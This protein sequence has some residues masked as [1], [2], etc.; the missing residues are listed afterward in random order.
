MPFCDRI[1]AREDNY[2][3]HIATH[4]HYQEIFICSAEDDYKGVHAINPLVMDESLANTRPFDAIPFKPIELDLWRFQERMR[5]M[6]VPDV[7]VGTSYIDKYFAANPEEAESALRGDPKW[8]WHVPE[9]GP[10][11]QYINSNCIK[12]KFK[13]D[14]KAAVTSTEQ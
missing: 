12:G 1:F 9:P 5:R 6:G 4:S 11:F 8:E 14:I 13:L 7:P 2:K 3:R 10:E